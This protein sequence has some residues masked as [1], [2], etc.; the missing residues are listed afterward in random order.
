[1]KRKPKIG[2]ITMHRVRKNGYAL[3]AY[4]LQT[5]VNEFGYDS[6]FFYC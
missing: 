6:K 4:A 2:I 1:M 5:K 3:Q